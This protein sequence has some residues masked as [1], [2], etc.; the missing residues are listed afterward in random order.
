MSSVPIDVVIFLHDPALADEIGIYLCLGVVE[1]RKVY[2]AESPAV[3]GEFYLWAHRS[4]FLEG[5]LPGAPSVSALAGA[6]IERLL[7]AAEVAVA[8]MYDPERLVAA[9]QPALSLQ[10]PGATV[11]VLTDCEL[12]P[13][14]GRRYRLMARTSQGLVASI[15]PADPAFWGSNDPQRF[16]T[17]KR[18]ARA[19]VGRMIG[20]LL[21]L[22][23]CENHQCFMYREERITSVSTLDMMRTVGA[24][25]AAAAGAEPLGF[26]EAPESDDATEADVK[27]GTDELWMGGWVKP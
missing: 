20:N 11:A 24:E 26:L 4:L 5:S 3:H 1:A 13:T 27:R 22:Q 23:E 10:Q 25:H 7:D 15:A 12:E 21:D 16:K 8:E 6:E 18:R 19:L 9:I 2:N 17:I 14:A